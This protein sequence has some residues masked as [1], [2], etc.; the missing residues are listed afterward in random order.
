[1]DF[2]GLHAGTQVQMN[3][4]AIASG[5][6]FL[7]SEL[8]KR[9][10]RLREPLTSF[11]YP[12][13][14]PISVGGGWVE[15][16]SALNIS[17]AL[18]GSS[19]SG[20][21]TTPAANGI[22]LVQANLGKDTFKTHQFGV[23]MRVSFVDMQRSG[24]LGRSLDQMLTQ[25]VRMAYDKHMEAN[26]Y[27]GLQDF[28]TT[29]LLNHAGAVAANVAA[30]GTGSS[31]AWKNKTPQQI[32]DD[33]NA[34]LADVWSA[35]EYDPSA[36]PNHILVPYEQYNHILTTKLTD[37]G[38]ETILDFLQKNNAADKNGGRLTIAPTRWCQGAGVGGTDRMAVY[39]N[40]ERFLKLEE[41]VPLSRVMTQPNAANLCYDTGYA[42]NLS[43]VEVFYP[44]CLRYYDGI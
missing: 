40:A 21:V 22:P 27:L 20:P 35:A 1:M 29:G 34:A 7:V 41:L 10:T 11:T 39:V 9:D 25:G 14:L 18:P 24:F 26:A 37:L 43:E 4:A 38:A 32:L 23:G 28:G 17:Y 42:A 5:G 19:V 2:T 30:N 8:E 3:D 33:V 13:D 36:M 31:P 6:A 16:I 15:S 44:Q 12:R